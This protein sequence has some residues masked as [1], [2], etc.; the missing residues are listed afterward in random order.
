MTNL[1]EGSPGSGPTAG[2]PSRLPL[3]VWPL[4]AILAVA[5]ICGGYLYLRAE[6]PPSE[7]FDLHNAPRIEALAAKIEAGAQGVV[8]IGDS[9]LRYALPEDVAFSRLLSQRLDMPAAALRLSNVWAIWSDFAGLAPQI[10]A[11]RPRL[12]ILQEDLFA[13]ERETGSR[14]LLGRTYLIWQVAGSGPWNPGNVDQAMLQTD[15]RCDVLSDENAHERKER[16]SEWVSFDAEGANAKAIAR[17]VAAAE[18][19]GIEIAVLPVPI[20]EEG[21]AVLPGYKRPADLR[22]IDHGITLSNDHYC[23]VVHMNAKGRAVFTEMLLG[24]LQARLG[25]TP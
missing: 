20:T 17:F 4:T 25:G 19:A 6:T 3:S 15:V 10:L 7:A 24:R 18:D 5:L 14:L 22:T 1:A 11:A 9:R 16:V 13:K 2:D 8:M 23:D 21:H 12:V